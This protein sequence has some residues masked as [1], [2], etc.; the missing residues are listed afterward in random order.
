LPELVP[1][2][3]WLT[4]TQRVQHLSRGRKFID[5]IRMQF[6][7]ETNPWFQETF[8]HPKNWSEQNRE[9]LST[10]RLAQSNASK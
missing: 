8:H 6:R 4:Y 3:F 5:W 2:E 10:V 7:H 1:I 9:R